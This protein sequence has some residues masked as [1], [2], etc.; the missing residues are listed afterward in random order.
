MQNITICEYHMQETLGAGVVA[1]LDTSVH[2]GMLRSC[3]QREY[4]RNDVLRRCFVG[5]TT[6]SG[7]RRRVVPA[8]EG[9]IG[10]VLTMDLMQLSW[11]EADD[12][13]RR[14]CCGDPRDDFPPF[15][16][17]VVRLPR[18]HNGFMLRVDRRL[19]EP[20]RLRA[21]AEDVFCLYGQRMCGS[22]VGPR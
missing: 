1:T 9:D 15:E 16:F 22:D 12:A 7:G 3:M 20:D 13:M 8:E 2:V 4:E 19:V 14:W 6:S 5:K 21:L 10:D 11:D 17:C 18:G